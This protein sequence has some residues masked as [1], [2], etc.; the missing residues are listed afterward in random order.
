MRR[1]DPRVILEAGHA[2]GNYDASKWIGE[3]DVPTSVLVTTEDR[4]IQ[5]STQYKMA[6]AIAGAEV[7]E[8]KAGHVLCAREEFAPPLLAAVGAV[9][10]RV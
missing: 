9:A 8:A 6:E 10:A 1:H 5:P 7:H 3:V 2:I 4:A